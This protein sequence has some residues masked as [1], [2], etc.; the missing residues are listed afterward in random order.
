MKYIL[1]R[2]VCLPVFLL[3]LQ[4]GEALGPHELL[5]LVNKNSP[6]SKQMA[7]HYV[8]MR[9]IPAQ[10]IVQLDLPDSVLEAG[11]EIS[12]TDFGRFIWNPAHTAMKQRGIGD[13]ILAWTYSA[14]FPVR[15]EGS[16][17]LSIQGI[18]FVRNIVPRPKSSTKGL[19][20]SPLFAGPNEAGGPQAPSHSFDGFK[21][22][23]RENMP[24]PSMMLGWTGARG[25]DVENALKCLSRGLLSDRSAPRGTVYFVVN[26]DVR[27]KC[28]DWQYP[29]AVQELFALHVASVIT[30]NF[31][32][33]KTDVLGLFCGIAWVNPDSVQAFLP[34][35]MADQF[36]SFAGVLDFFDQTKLTDWLVAGATA[37]AGQIAEPYAMWTKFPNARFYAHYASGCTMIESFFQS[38]RCPLQL[39]MVGDPLAS[40]WAPNQSM[41]LVQSDDGTNPEKAFFT[42][43]FSPS[44][45]VLNPIICTSSM[46]AS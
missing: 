7:N 8:R 6:R 34:G 22:R 43:R 21:G 3:T 36:T 11:A 19:Y 18:T 24:V 1:K 45:Q 38:I 44:L 40:P 16:P 14:D 35:C 42:P 12:S 26:S 13:H 5:L 4:L 37:S 23:L 33:G 17:Q 31:P 2:L 29:A 46:D 10:N 32:S 27:S 9:Q 15:I 25:M 41:I 20:S 39:L 28:R 30:P